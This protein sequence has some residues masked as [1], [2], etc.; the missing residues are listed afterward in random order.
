MPVKR[1]YSFT[2]NKP[3]PHSAICCDFIVPAWDRSVNQICQG[4]TIFP[5]VIKTVLE[6][7]RNIFQTVFFIWK[8]VDKGHGQIEFQLITEPVSRFRRKSVK[9]RL[10][11][12][13][14]SYFYRRLVFL[15]ALS[16]KSGKNPVW[17]KGLNSGNI[18]GIDFFRY[19]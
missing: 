19:G 6:S 2:D 8:M 7:N 11:G 14:C 17:G 5:F 13:F 9:V 12:P 16:T 10:S 15:Q 18:K 3:Y 1:S 4:R